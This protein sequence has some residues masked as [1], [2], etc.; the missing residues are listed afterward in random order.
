MRKSSNSLSSGFSCF[1]HDPN[2]YIKH[3]N[4]DN[5]IL[6]ISANDL[7]LTGNSPRMIVDIKKK[8]MGIYKMTN[9]VFLHYFLGM[10]VL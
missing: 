8:L 3:I 7:V 1:H 10:Q 9:L 2:F 6:V 4:E 5:L